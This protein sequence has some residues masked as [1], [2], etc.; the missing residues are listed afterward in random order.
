MPKYF[1]TSP[2]VVACLSN[3]MSSLFARVSILFKRGSGNRMRKYSRQE[4]VKLSSEPAWIISP[5]GVFKLHSRRWTGVQK[6]TLNL[7]SSL[8]HSLSWTMVPE[9]GLQINYQLADQGRVSKAGWLRVTLLTRKLIY[10]LL[11]AKQWCDYYP[12]LLAK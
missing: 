10:W 11:L 4:H 12:M 6:S 2:A 8:N 7:S 9:L 1:N 5:T 3:G